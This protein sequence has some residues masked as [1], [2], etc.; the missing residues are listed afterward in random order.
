MKFYARK[1]EE[2]GEPRVQIQ[3]GGCVRKPRDDVDGRRVNYTPRY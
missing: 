3:E 2:E 1:E